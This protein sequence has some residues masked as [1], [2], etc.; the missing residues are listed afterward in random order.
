M[1]QQFEN[2][3]LE[4]LAKNA[5]F[6]LV[7]GVGAGQVFDLS[8]SRVAIGRELD[9]DICLQN[10]SVSRHHAIIERTSEGT[11]RIFDNQSKNGIFINA[12]KVEVAVLQHGD[13]VQ[14]GAFTFRFTLAGEP[15]ELE[16][17]NK[18]MAE[19]EQAAPEM[20]GGR[21][22]PIPNN[23]RKRILVYSLGGLLLA[24]L[25]MMSSDETPTEDANEPKQ[26]DSKFKVTDAPKFENGS[27]PPEERL[28]ADPLLSNAE[29]ELSKLDWSNTSIKESEAYFRKGQREY[30]SKNFH[31]AIDNFK[32]SLAIFKSHPLSRYYLQAAIHDAEL[33][34]KKHY[35]IGIKYFESLQYSRA[36]YHFSEVIQLMSHRS[37]DQVVQE[38]ERYIKL[39][40][41]K[42]Q[43]AEMFP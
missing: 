32:A 39:A 16:H 9:N 18:E 42:L 31:R 30:F 41:Q 12:D 27:I 8:S 22:T 7:A 38:A 29:E 5:T 13:L 15:V 1:S 34:A 23:N 40:K 14:V 43:A 4:E 28:K 17:E 26:G 20:Y 2:I 21:A 3:G 33:E 24:G 25:Y 11:Y 10:E 19:A 37:Q 35:E 6:E 36:V